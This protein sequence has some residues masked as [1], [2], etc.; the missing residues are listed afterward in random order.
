MEERQKCFIVRDLLESYEDELV[1]PETGEMIKEHL[2]SCSKCQKS[3]KK[4]QAQRQEQAELEQLQGN[5]FQRKLLG[6]Q[7]L[8]F[9]LGVLLTI[10]IVLASGFVLLLWTKLMMYGSQLLEGL[11]RFL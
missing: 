1:N 9:F 2:Q 6:Y 7:M 5:K 10:G 3:Y 8:G 11:I 4:M